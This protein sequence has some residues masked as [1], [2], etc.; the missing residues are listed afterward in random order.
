MVA[1]L[2]RNNFV[3]HLKQHNTMKLNYIYLVMAIAII[4]SCR[5]DDVP[6][7]TD[8]QTKVL[9]SNLNFP[10][11]IL[12]GP[13]STI[14]MTERLGRV[15][16]VNPGT[17]LVTPLINI[18][19]VASYTDFNGLVGMVLHPQFTTIPQVFVVYNYGSRTNYKEKVVRYTYNN[20]TLI[21]PLIIV[22]NIRGIDSGSAVHNGSRLLISS[23]LK[24]FITTGDAQDTT[25]PQNM[26]SLNGKILRVN[27]DGSIP[28]DN[29]FPNSPIWTLGHRNVQG[30]VMIGNK[31]LISEHGANSDD[32]IN[33]VEK[34]RNY[35]WPSV[36]GMC[37]LANEQIFCSANNVMQPIITWTPI[38][39]P[40]GLD[41][42]TSDYI[43]QWKNSI[44]LTTLKDMQLKQLKFNGTSITDTSSYFIHQFGRLRDLA[45]SPEGKVYICTDNGNNNDV[46]VEV[47]RR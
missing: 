22:D 37:N 2:N 9:T 38:I 8:I 7:S 27:L 40:S 10:W 12:W 34:G 28:A 14:W 26:A 17:G 32:E 5:K 16:R 13:D 11:E 20:A 44:L 18:S 25:L 36:Q 43:P 46:I 35:G 47:S 21:N 1:L 6:A 30:I 45:I 39:A 31:L 15:S 29:P 23:D 41:Y 42:Y 4:F 24:L 33:I 19:D 3:V